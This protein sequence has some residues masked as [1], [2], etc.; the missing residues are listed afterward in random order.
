[1]SKD[2]QSYADLLFQQESE[3]IKKTIRLKVFSTQ[4]RDQ[5]IAQRTRRV[6]ELERCD[7]NLIEECIRN[8][9][10]GEEPMTLLLYTEGSLTEALRKASADDRARLREAIVCLKNSGINFDRASLAY[11]SRILCRC[12]A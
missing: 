8:V 12:R 10:N 1:M 11:M 3:H 5:E 7:L 2:N 6:R 9:I 4:T